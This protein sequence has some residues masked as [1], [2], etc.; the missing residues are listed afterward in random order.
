MVFSFSSLA[1]ISPTLFILIQP[2][3]TLIATLSTLQ[4]TDPNVGKIHGQEQSLQHGA[5]YNL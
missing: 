2:P 5:V 4:I 3:M 1:S